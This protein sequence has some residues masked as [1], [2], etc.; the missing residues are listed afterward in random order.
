MN[1]KLF[2]KLAAKEKSFRDQLFLSPVV[3]GQSV[4]VRIAEIVMRLSVSEPDGFEGWGVFQPVNFNQAR[5]VRDPN[6]MERSK[7]LDLFPSVRLVLSHRK[8][9]RWFGIPITESES[10]FGADQVVPLQ[11]ASGCQPFE[12]VIARFDGQACWFDKR[13]PRRPA[14]IAKELRRRLAELIDPN[15]IAVSGA[16]QAEKTAYERNWF[17]NI[18]NIKLDQINSDE[19]RIKKSLERGGAKFHSFRET[20]NSFTV[21]YEVNGQ[22]HH[23]TVDSKTLSVQSAGICLDG[24]DANFDL[25]SLVGV[26]VEGQQNGE[27]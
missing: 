10:R 20:G 16:N 18:D 3:K 13:D 23:S 27:F 25:Q 17:W 24:Y 5:W 21:T 26:I 19:L 22:Q 4:Q 7:Y 12:T 1:K 6:K 9:N 11:L 15:N 8:K 14:R 2:A